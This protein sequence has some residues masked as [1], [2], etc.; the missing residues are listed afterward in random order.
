MQSSLACST[1]WPQALT[2]AS[3]TMNLR[4]LRPVTE[5]EIQK[6]ER[7]GFVHLENILSD[8]WVT[9]LDR[10]I[11][12][13]AANPSGQVIDFTTLGMMAEATETVDALVADGE[14]KD[15]EKRAWA[16]PAAMANNILREEVAVENAQRGHFVSMTGA[17]RRC[18]PINELVC[19]SPVPEIASRLMRSKKVYVY[20]DQVLL[21]PPYT[22]EKTAWHQDNGYDHVAGDQLLGIRIPTTRETMEMGPV[23]YLRGSHKDGVI[24]KVNYFISEVGN[25]RDTGAPIP[26]IEGHEQDF[27]VEYCQ[28]Q[29]GDVVV[30]HLRTLHG[31]GGNRSK[32][33]ARKAI[34]IRYA[35]DDARFL[36]RPFA[37][38]QDVFH[39]KNGDPLDL[40]PA[41]H[42][43]VW[44]R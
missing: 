11:E 41:N 37:P 39:L 7:D 28:P 30:H 42:P 18:E 32:T 35:G 15:P 12:A 20:D 44:P 6:F 33:T 25:E 38:P 34:T 29:P 23:G 26:D 10:T 19:K 14:W 9:L 36:H 3:T 8:D 22:L 2:E 13:L 4:P 17:F 5:E 43:V 40:D 27:A 21:K 1:A 24:Y 31:A 16:S